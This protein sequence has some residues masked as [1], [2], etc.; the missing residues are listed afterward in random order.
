[1]SRPLVEAAASLARIGAG[2]ATAPLKVRS[3]DE[4]GEI[5]EAVNGLVQR[6]RTTEHAR[7]LADEAL[8]KSE[9]KFSKVFRSAPVGIAVTGHADGRIVESNDEF[10]KLLGYRRDEVIGRTSIE[11]GIWP[12]PTVREALAASLTL[13]GTFSSEQQFRAKDGEA[14]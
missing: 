12:D 6:T 2:D 11:L 3:T 4:I 5:V 9:E 7:N 1:L 14:R 10:L 8:R 13:Q